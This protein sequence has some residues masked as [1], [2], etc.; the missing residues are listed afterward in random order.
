MMNQAKQLPELSQGH[1]TLS[2]VLTSSQER[3]IDMQDLIGWRGDGTLKFQKEK[4]ALCSSGTVESKDEDVLWETVASMSNEVRD[5]RTKE[6]RSQDKP[7]FT[8]CRAAE[9]LHFQRP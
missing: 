8:E 6:T 4:D 3:K 2:A 1:L 5:T 9:G 7:G